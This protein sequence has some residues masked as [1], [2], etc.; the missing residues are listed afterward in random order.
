MQ[1]SNIILDK[2]RN[3]MQCTPLSLRLTFKIEGSRLL[4]CGGVRLD[5]SMETGPLMVYFQNSRK[6]CLSDWT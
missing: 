4:Q 6:V 3:A 2:D 1:S 5:N